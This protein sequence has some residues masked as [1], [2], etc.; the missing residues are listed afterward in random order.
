MKHFTKTLEDF[1]C[2]NCGLSVYGNGYT[3]HCPKCLYSLHVD[4]YPGD[5]QENCQGLMKPID[6]ISKGGYPVDIVHE[7]QICHTIKHNKVNDN[8][9]TDTIIEVMKEKVK[10]EMMR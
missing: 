1:I 8:D 10:K 7:C 6:I 2:K 4:N 5:R 3:N 9:S